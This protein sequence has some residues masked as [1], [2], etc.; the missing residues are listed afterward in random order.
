MDK[1]SFGLEEVV[2]L[3]ECLVIAKSATKE[4][5]VRPKWIES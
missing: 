5:S 2:T 3:E 4:E 1:K